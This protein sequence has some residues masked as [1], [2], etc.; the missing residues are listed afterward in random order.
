LI[1]CGLGNPKW[2]FSQCL[3]E[4]NAWKTAPGDASVMYKPV[5]G[6]RNGQRNALHLSLSLMQEWSTRFQHPFNYEFV[7]WRKHNKLHM[8][9]KCRWTWN[10]LSIQ[11]HVSLSRSSLFRDALLQQQQGATS[12][13]THAAFC[14]VGSWFSFVHPFG[15]QFLFTPEH[16]SPH[17]GIQLNHL[18]QLITW[19][20]H[21][22]P[23]VKG[24]PA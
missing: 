10:T 8:F 16:T 13:A 3:C 11:T 4:R 20:D 7:A 17:N 19:Q 23:E 1:L 9:R 18:T 12:N 14:V 2:R 21:I 22:L 15:M 5:L 6:T 24:R